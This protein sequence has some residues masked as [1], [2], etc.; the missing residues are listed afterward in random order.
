MNLREIQ[1]QVVFAEFGIIYHHYIQLNAL[2]YVK[3]TAIVK[4][5]EACHYFDYQ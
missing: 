4:D 1:Y 5:H 3:L 2:L